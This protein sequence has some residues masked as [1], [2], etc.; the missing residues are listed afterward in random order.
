MYLDRILKW[1]CRLHC[2]N[3]GIGYRFIGTYLLT[4]ICSEANR[5]TKYSTEGEIVLATSVEE[6]LKAHESSKTSFLLGFQNA[7]ALEKNIDAIDEFYNAGLRVFA[8]THIGNNDFA[9]SSRPAFD[10]ASGT[11]EGA[12]HGGLSDLGRQAVQRINDLGALVD[13]SQLSKKASLQ[14]LETTKAPIVATHSNVRTISDVSRNLSDEEID[15]IGKNGGVIHLSPFR[16]YLKDYSD[17]QFLSDIRATRRAAGISEDYSYPFELYWEIEELADKMRFL[18]AMSDLLGPA[19]VSEFV[20]HIDYVVDRI[21]IDHAGIGSDFNHGSG[22]EG[23][24]EASDA[25]NVTIELVRRGYT[26]KEIEKIWSGNFLRVF[27]QANAL[28][29]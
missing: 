20:D 22:V 16:A 1:L 28:R 21:G 3:F 6:L 5:Y 25:L 14:V 9:D 13:V 18:H 7:R 2:N 8:L 4:F 15:M 23:F 10:G 27:A 19:Y 26:Q 29:K 17:E 11:Y 24:Q 12:E